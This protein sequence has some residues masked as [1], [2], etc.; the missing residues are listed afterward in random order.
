M[1]ALDREV[2]KG[3]TEIVGTL[4][5]PI[6]VVPGGW[7]ESLPEWLKKRVTL[8]RLA[9]NMLALKEGREPT[10]TDA[11]AACYLWRAAAPG[12]IV[13]YLARRGV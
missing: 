2:D 3:I 5:D 11:E 13:S 7:G 1:K 12:D 8:E 4:F 9:E 6:I 10:A